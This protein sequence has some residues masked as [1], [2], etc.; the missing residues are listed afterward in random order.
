MH[1]YYVS[2]TQFC[3]LLVIAIAIF[4]GSHKF[5]QAFY[6]EKRKGIG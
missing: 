3:H 6:G 1:Y 5:P 4:I 2:V